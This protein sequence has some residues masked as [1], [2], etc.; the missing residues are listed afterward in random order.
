MKSRREMDR[1]TIGQ[2]GAAD[3]RMQKPFVQTPR[4]KTWISRGTRSVADHQTGHQQSRV[5]KWVQ[6][7]HQG[8][9]R[10]LFYFDY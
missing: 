6:N 4:D 8:T 10:K 5:Y 9:D 1:Y 2:Q 7:I 3:D